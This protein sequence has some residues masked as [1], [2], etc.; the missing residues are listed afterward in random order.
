MS[1]TLSLNWGVDIATFCHR[2]HDR[3]GARAQTRGMRGS[4]EYLELGEHVSMKKSMTSESNRPRIGDVPEGATPESR[5]QQ[6]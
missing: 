4:V 6:S 5:V 3:V 1:L 2:D